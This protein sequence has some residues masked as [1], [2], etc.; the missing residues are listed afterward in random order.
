M[1]PVRFC[2]EAERAQLFREFLHQPGI[3]EALLQVLT[4]VQWC[5]GSML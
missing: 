4:C 2:L 1:V 5:T 3:W